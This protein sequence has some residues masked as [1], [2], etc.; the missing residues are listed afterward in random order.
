MSTRGRKP[1]ETTPKERFADKIIVSGD[2]WIWDGDYGKRGLPLFHARY[3]G[4]IVSGSA[5]K[6]S[7]EMSKGKIPSG[8]EVKVVCGDL[9]CVNPEHLTINTD[10]NGFWE[11]VV[12]SSGEEC[13]LWTGAVDSVGYGCFRGKKAHR[14]SYEIHFGKFD[15]SLDVLHQCDNVWCV[16]PSHLFLGTHA[17]NMADMVAKGRS[18]RGEESGKHKLTEREVLRIRKRIAAGE[19]DLQIAPDF[20]V[21]HGAIRSIRIKRSWFWLESV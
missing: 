21:S 20:R 5:R 3:N 9:R 10:K 2:C 15:K 12:V 16:N 8:R 11:K 7:W 4:E 14:F 19:S 18:K 17:D 13:W 1:L 6:F